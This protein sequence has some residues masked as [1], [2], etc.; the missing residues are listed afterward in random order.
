MELDG[1][2]NKS[3][4][5]YE[6]KSIREKLEKNQSAASLCYAIAAACFIIVLL[7]ILQYNGY[8]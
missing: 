6:Y 5:R 3:N 1:F 2:K 8:F 4:Y 7:M